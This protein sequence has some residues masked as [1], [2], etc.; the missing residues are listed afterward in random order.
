VDEVR[1]DGG[2]PRFALSSRADPR[3]GRSHARTG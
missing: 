2:R 3:T 1:D